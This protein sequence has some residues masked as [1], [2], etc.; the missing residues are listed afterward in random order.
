LKLR[1]FT[2]PPPHH[3]QYGSVKVHVLKERSPLVPLKKGE[4]EP[5]LAPLFKGGWGDQV[6]SEPYCHHRQ[7]LNYFILFGHKMIFL[8]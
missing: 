7:V 1:I 3:R 4:I 6:L 5:L 8:L 2:L